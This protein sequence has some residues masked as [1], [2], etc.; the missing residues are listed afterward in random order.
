LR[1]GFDIAPESLGVAAPAAPAGADVVAA[2]ADSNPERIP[3]VMLSPGFAGLVLLAA[4]AAA[5]AAEFAGVCAG[6]GAG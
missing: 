4:F 2:G 5:G 6:G 3:S 1:N